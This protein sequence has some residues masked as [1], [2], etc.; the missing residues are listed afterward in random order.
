MR[1]FLFPS[2]MLAAVLLTAFTGCKNLEKPVLARTDAQLAGDIQSKLMGDK[3]FSS[4][5]SPD[6]HVAVTNGVA[7]LSGEAADDNA[8]ILAGSDASQVNGV[9]QVVNDI[10]VPSGEAAQECVPPA[11]VHRA[12]LRVKARHERAPEL[13]SSYEAPA[14][15]PMMAPPPV[16]APA[17]AYFVPPAPVVVPVRPLFYGRYHRGYWGRPARP[18]AYRPGVSVHIHP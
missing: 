9:K 3:T 12:H 11:P 17:P 13:A 5:E 18:Y 1:K 15:A 2:L 7:T 10:T 4:P 8:R 14:P 6:V 16:Y